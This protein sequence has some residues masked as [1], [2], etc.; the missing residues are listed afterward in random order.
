[1]TQINIAYSTDDNYAQHAGASIASV[2]ENNIQIDEI[3]FYI[4]NNNI[5]EKSKSN[6]EAI[7][8]KYNNAVLHFIDFDMYKEKLK[9]N[10]EWE[11]SISS[12]ARL[13][14]AS[15]L[16]ETVDKILYFD[17]DTI[18]VDSIE[19]LWMTDI[20]NYK[21]AGVQDTVNLSVKK[22]VDMPLEYRYVNAGMLL[23]NIKA[24][25]VAK[26]EELFLDFINSK[27][28]NVIHHDQGVING[29]LHKECKIVDLKFNFMTIH[30]FMKRRKLLKYF[31]VIEEYYSSEDVLK[32]KENPVY[33]HYT[34][35]FTSRPWVS[36]C[37]HPKKD[38][39]WKYLGLTPWKN[40]EPIVDNSKNHVHIINWMYK[41]L[42]IGF[43]RTIVNLAKMVRG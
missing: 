42:P 41:N 8:N 21:I 2:L 36:S 1:M 33:I 22:A 40:E 12:Y 16:P 37:E 13:F 9:L 43:S 17:C 23:I 38:L 26:V 32:A 39:Y 11:I 7:V 24:W 35:S 15:M 30:Y 34:P 25:R 27:N 29:V 6:L 10:M 5:T 19:D 31:G 14:L 4:I 3:I 18:I 28:G 20:E